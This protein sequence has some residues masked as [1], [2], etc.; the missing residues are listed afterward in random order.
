V[1]SHAPTRWKSQAVHITMTMSVLNVPA[2]AFDDT[3]KYV[4]LVKLRNGSSVPAIAHHRSNTQSEMQSI[5]SKQSRQ[6][7]KRHT[8]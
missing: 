2:R 6:R 8:T 1:F 5:E 7:N 3:D 4:K